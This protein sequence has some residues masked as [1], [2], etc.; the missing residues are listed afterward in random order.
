MLNARKINDEK[1]IFQGAQSNLMYMAIVFIIVA[2]QII[3]IEFGD[4][5]FKV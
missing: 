4:V 5:A 1:N 3:I 2:G